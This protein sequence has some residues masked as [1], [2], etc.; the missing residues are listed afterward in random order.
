MK[1]TPNKKVII[2]VNM[3]CSSGTFYTS[4]ISKSL[5]ANP[6]IIDE[7][8]PNV[9][10]DYGLKAFSLSVPLLKECLKGRIGYEEWERAY[11]S[12][13][14]AI[15]V[16]WNKS[17]STLLTFR[18]HAWTDAKSKHTKTLGQIL[19]ELGITFKVI[20]THRDPIDTWLGMASSFPE[21]VEDENLTSFSRIYMTSIKQWGE[22]T[23][24]GQLIHIQTEQISRNPKD[25]LSHLAK[26]LDIGSEEICLTHVGI[27]EL[28]SGAS[29]RK[30]T[31][32]TIPIRRPYSIRMAQEA[33]KATEFKK[34]QS[35]LGYREGIGKQSF[36]QRVTSIW[37]A[38]YQ[39][40][41]RIEVTPGL[42]LVVLA[43]K[44]GLKIA[45]Y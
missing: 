6:W 8:S 28:G 23:L 38:T 11:K 13:I 45:F 33:S 25:S 2:I 39:P 27:K 7:T 4:F 42:K 32:P 22:S 12:Q 21:S 1:I 16:H 30:F 15:L 41:L 20:Y 31:Y 44:L 18:A 9:P 37:H 19:S 35:Y 29:G 40:F 10:N 14:E 3:P 26:R 36:W 34:L 5:S 24:D 17:S 43:S